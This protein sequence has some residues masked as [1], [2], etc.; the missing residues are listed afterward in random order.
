M[1]EIKMRKAKR[2]MNCTAWI[3]SKVWTKVVVSVFYKSRVL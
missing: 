2:R 1:E 3:D